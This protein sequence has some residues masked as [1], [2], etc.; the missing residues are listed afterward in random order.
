ML[1][2]FVRICDCFIMDDKTYVLG[3]FSQL[4]GQEFYVAD[5]RGNVAEEFR[6]QKRSKF[7]R[8]FWY[9]KPF[10]LVVYEAVLSLPQV[11]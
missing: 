10:V 6:V 9:G 7:Q 11:P 8:S 2:D 3:N 4:P 1:S 5:A